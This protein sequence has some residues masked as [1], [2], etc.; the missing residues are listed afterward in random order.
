MKRVVIIEDETAA[1]ANLEAIL[2]E[3]LDDQIEVVAQ[4]ESVAES[5][6]YFKGSQM[7]DIVFMDIHLADGDSFRILGSV[8]ITAPI[9]FTTAYDQYA[10]EAFKFNSIDY[11]LKPISKSDLERALGKLANLTLSQKSELGKRIKSVATNRTEQQSQQQGVIVHQRDKIIPISR[12]NIAYIYTRDERVT[13]CDLKGNTYTLNR[14]LESMQSQLPESDFIR[15]NRQ[16]II[17][18]QAISEISVWFGSRLTVSLLVETPERIVI[19]KAKVAEFKS[20]LT[21]I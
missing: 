9:I 15:A 18:R 10:L 17:S 5:I 21:A 1:A 7:P 20:W 19:P 12:S 16:F 14:T 6:E 8:D 2:R 11:L 3:L 13:I 4:L